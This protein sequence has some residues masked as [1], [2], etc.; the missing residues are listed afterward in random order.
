[1]RAIFDSRKEKFFAGWIRRLVG[2][3]QT[4][5]CAQAIWHVPKLAERRDG[6]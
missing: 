6:A 4:E 2:S 1:M 3:D 5:F